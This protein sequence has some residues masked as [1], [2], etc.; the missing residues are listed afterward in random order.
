MGVHFS[1]PYSYGV[2]LLSAQVKTGAFKKRDPTVIERGG[3]ADM[4]SIRRPCKIWSLLSRKIRMRRGI[5][6]ELVLV[7]VDPDQILSGVH[8]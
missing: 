6:L 5:L 4:E 1:I 8:M 3:D 7:G 2:S